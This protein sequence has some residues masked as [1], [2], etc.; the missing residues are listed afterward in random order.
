MQT[1]AVSTEVKLNT[2]SS[3]EEVTEA[4]VDYHSL[5]TENFRSKDWSKELRS[6]EDV[7]AGFSEEPM[8]EAPDEPSILMG[9]N[10]SSSVF[11]FFSENEAD[12]PLAVTIT[13][14]TT[15]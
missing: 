11:F 1:F 5:P 7:I 14:L 6:K 2:L 3:E 8:T 9:S 15:F 4:T 12:S 10:E 13:L